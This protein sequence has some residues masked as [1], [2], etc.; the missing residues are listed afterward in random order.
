MC[1]AWLRLVQKV[2]TSHLGAVQRLQAK[3]FLLLYAQWMQDTWLKP[4]VCLKLS[5]LWRALP[6][7]AAGPLGVPLG[8]CHNWIP[9]EYLMRRHQEVMREFLEFKKARIA[10]HGGHT[11]NPNTQ[12]TKAKGP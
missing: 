11:C 10:G 5:K 9:S 4:F 1:W 8:Q 7:E 3:D 6:Q 2:P 12:E